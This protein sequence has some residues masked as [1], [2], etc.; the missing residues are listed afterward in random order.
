MTELIVNGYTIE[1]RTARNIRNM[2]LRM[3]LGKGI[4]VNVP[5]GFTKSQ[6]VEFV[7]KHADW[8]EANYNKF[9]SIKE[10]L[11]HKVGDT[12]ECRFHTIKLCEHSGAEFA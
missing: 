9:A 3:A 7:N 4:W 8:I 12:I 1:V 10:A 5:Y 2:S 6:V 11:N